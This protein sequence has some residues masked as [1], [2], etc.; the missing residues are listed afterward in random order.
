MFYS[1]QEIN[2]FPITCKNV[3]DFC[4][5][6]LRLNEAKNGAENILKKKLWHILSEHKKKIIGV[7]P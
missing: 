5:E 4:K 6:L 2:L 1:I 3:H 7:S